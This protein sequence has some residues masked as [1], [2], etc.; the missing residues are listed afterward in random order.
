MLRDKLS[1][2]DDPSWVSRIIASQPSFTNAVAVWSILNRLTDRHADPSDRQVILVNDWLG[3]WQAAI[4]NHARVEHVCASAL[5]SEKPA[6]RK[7]FESLPLYWRGGRKVD[8]IGGLAIHGDRGEP[9]VIINMNW[10][11]PVLGS[12]GVR[13]WPGLMTRCT[14]VGKLVANLV[15]LHRTH[16]SVLVCLLLPGRNTATFTTDK[17]EIG[18]ASKAK[19]VIRDTPSGERRAAVFGGPA[20]EP[21]VSTLTAATSRLTALNAGGGDGKSGPGADA[22]MFVAHQPIG[23][24][25]AVFLRL[26]PV[27]AL[28]GQVAPLR[29]SPQVE[30]D[31]F[32]KAVAEAWDD[33]STQLSTWLPAQ[34]WSEH[35]QRQHKAVSRKR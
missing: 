1:T 15:L 33:T 31:S 2:A 17:R 11:S 4:S 35:M 32:K 28:G 5:M 22:F 13:S 26:W 24:L 7:M 12:D 34:Q 18:R 23:P 30:W 9:I 14:E 27:N 16:Q 3:T 21:V 8:D 19:T 25:A 29:A 20:T 6:E 10:D